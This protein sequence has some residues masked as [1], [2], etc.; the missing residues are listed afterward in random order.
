MARFRS[1]EPCDRGKAVAAFGSMPGLERQP[2]PP[3]E[4]RGFTALVRATRRQ[5]CDWLS[6]RTVEMA[7]VAA[8]AVVDSR[9]AR[10]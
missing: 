3:Q 9:P 8:V 10:P 2:N 6:E 4:Y 5:Q 7:R 1:D